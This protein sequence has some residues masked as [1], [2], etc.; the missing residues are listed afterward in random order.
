MAINS[1]QAIFSSGELS[2]KLH[3]RADTEFFKKGLKACENWLVM[4]QG[5]ITRRPGTQ[6]IGEV[7]DSSK[8]V[9]LLPFAYV[10]QTY[11][12]EI[13]DFYFRVYAL[14]G[15]VGT[16]EVVT[17]WAVA[18][19]FNLDYDQTNEVLDVVHKS[20]QPRRINRVAD[21][22]WTLTTTSNR[23]GPYL[24]VNATATTLTPS[25]TGNPIPIM[26]SATL[27]SGTAAASTTLA[28]QN[29]W[30]AFDG[31]TSTTWATNSVSN[32]WIYYEFTSSKIIVGYAITAGT[33]FGGGSGAIETDGAP[34]S[35]TFE[36][37]DGAA[38]VVLDVQ[39]AQI[40]WSGSET[41]YFAITNTTSYIRYRLNITSNNGNPC[42]FIAELAFTEDMTTAPAI[43][44]TASSIT[45]INHDA[46]F[47]STDVGRTIAILGG[48]AVYRAFQIS[49]YLST[50]VV[51]AKLDDA[52]LPAAQKTT[53]WRLGAWGN[54][55]GWP[56]HVC[57]FRG[58]KMFA[59]TNEQPNGVWGTKSGGYGTFLNFGISVPIVADDAIT[60]ILED[61]NEIGWIAEGSDMMMGT[62]GAAR[63]LGQATVNQAFSA[64][65]FQQLR[66]STHGSAAV[67]PVSVGDSTVFVSLMSKALREFVRSDSG[68]GYDTPDISVLS[69][70]MYASGVTQLAYAQEPD[71]IIW[72][73]NG[74]GELI[75]FTYEKAQSVAGL[76][77]HSLGGDGFVESVCTIPATDRTEVWLV[78]RRMINGTTKR[79]IERMSAKFDSLT[80][81]AAD[82][83]YLDCALQYFGAAVTSVGGL[84]H[85]EGQTVGILADGAREADAMVVAGTVSLA[86]GRAA[87]K[88]T[89]GLTYRS[90]AR[91]L[92]SPMSRGDGSGLGR[93]KKVV[94]ALL[95]L[96]DTGSIK[97]GRTVATVEEV[98]FR[99]TTDDLGEAVPLATGFYKI[100]ADGS[101][102]DKGEVEIVA[103]GP[104]PATV[105]SLTLDLE[106]E[107]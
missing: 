12:L 33:G 6:F 22:N 7:K 57:T 36:G 66:A 70:Q 55:P 89:V 101:W 59:R 17:P 14:G 42:I 88:I 2:P 105:R 74:D 25:G 47:S 73:P 58:R 13:G 80:D 53:Q 68:V 71:S 1:L 64:T 35:W 38:Y 63:T 28:G 31:D 46:G 84:S 65:N 69:E 93:K 76:H 15:R 18:D 90:R 60:F 43:T 96:L 61:A 103:D 30:H 78:V 86:S 23:F 50:T 49:A 79:Y 51:E 10:G 54:M 91:T 83:W 100:R 81:D 72:A 52:P 4:R 97:V 106:T 92:P 16:V 77:R 44:I 8:A 75:G 104:F 82:A 56:A 3:S 40:N 48:N 37:W 41:R 39:Y 107:P 45:G 94:S 98:K 11:V 62:A 27:P 29:E 20:Y 99:D 85:L 87:S 32:G 5:G 34:K 67:R 19:I 21:T 102:A 24:S 26:T 9:R 95:D